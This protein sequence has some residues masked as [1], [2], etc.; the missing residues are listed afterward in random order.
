MGRQVWYSGVLLGYLIVEQTG[1]P[2][3]WEA[4]E[5]MHMQIALSYLVQAYNTKQW[6]TKYYPEQM[7]DGDLSNFVD[8]EKEEM[9]RKLSDHAFYTSHTI[10]HPVT[11]ILALVDLIKSNWEDRENYESL[12]T[13]LKIETM[14]LDETIRVMSAKIELD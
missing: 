7:S 2:R 12:L 8:K 3:K 5:E 1:K 4:I 10:R 11:T 14:H 6:L 9:R 13:Q